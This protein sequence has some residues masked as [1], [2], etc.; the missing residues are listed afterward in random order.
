MTIEIL[1]FYE[2]E[3]EK[4]KESF[5]QNVKDGLQVGAS[6]ALTVNGKCVVDIWAGHKDAAKTLPWEKDT[7]VTVYS[8]TNR[9]IALGYQ[10]HRPSQ[11]GEF[12]LQ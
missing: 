7:L 5:H 12:F 2:P 11:K 9:S 3:S 10:Q 4:L 8:S 6:Y 1:G